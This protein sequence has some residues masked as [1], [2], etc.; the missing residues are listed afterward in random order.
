VLRGSSYHRNHNKNDKSNSNN[1]TAELVKLKADNRDL[2][3][4]VNTIEAKLKASVEAASRFEM[5]LFEQG[6][7]CANRRITLS[8]SKQ[9]W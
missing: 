8:C 6:L 2:T 9:I 4:Q 3:L 7:S 1:I 5:Q